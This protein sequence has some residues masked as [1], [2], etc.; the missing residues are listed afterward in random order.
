MMNRK[1]LVLTVILAVL[2]VL[3][4]TVF[5]ATTRPAM[6]QQQVGGSAVW[7]A[8]H[9]MFSTISVGAYHTLA[10]DTSGVLW[11]WGDNS[12]GAVGDGTTTYRS[13][14]VRIMENVVAVSAGSFLG[15]SY[16]L[17][18]QNDGSLWGWGHNFCG[19]LG[20]GT[21]VNPR[22]S[23]V[24]IMAN[25]TAFSTGAGHTLAIDT[26]GRL[27]AWGRN[28][29]GEL[30]D[31]TTTWRNSPVQ[32][33]SNIVQVSAGAGFS[34]AISA[35]NEL[36]AWGGN[37]VGQ[38]GDGTTTNRNRPTLIGENIVD[39]S[40]GTTHSLA[41]DTL[42]V[43]WA[44][45]SNS[46]GQL[47]D[48][49]TTN[50]L[51]PVVIMENVVG[52]SATRYIPT[53]GNVTGS[54]MALTVDGRLFT[55][56]NNTNG[57]LGDGTT[58]NR[59]RP[60]QIQQNII[61][62]SMGLTSAAA[63]QNDGTLLVWGANNRGQLGDG[64][65]TQRTSPVQISGIRIMLPLHRP[66]AG[67][68]T[69]SIPSANEVQQPTV[70][71]SSML[72]NNWG[73]FNNISH[74]VASTFR[75]TLA[76][77]NDG[78]LW[79]WGANTDGQLGDGTRT[80]RTRPV[81][82]MD[83]VVAVSS[84]SFGHSSGYSLALTSNGVLYGWGNNNS[85]QL[86][87]GSSRIR[88]SRIMDNIVAFS[89]SNAH[90]L[91][92]D[93][94]G[95]LWAW[96]SNSAGQL[97]DGTTT[98]RSRP[99][100]IG[101]N[102]VSVSAGA[103]HSMA[104]DASGNLFAWGS[105]S[106]GQLGDGTTTNRN[107]PVHIGSNVADVLAGARHTLAID[108]DGSLYGWGSN[109]AGQLG[110][111]STTD[112]HNPIFI[113]NNV[114]AIGA[115]NNARTGHDRMGNSLAV[116]SDGT[117]YSWGWNNFGNVGDGTTTNRHRPVPIMTHVAAVS[118]GSSAGAAVRTDGTLWTW[119][120]NEGNIGDGTTINRHSP[121][122]VLDIDNIMLPTN[123][124][125]VMPPAATTPLPAPTIGLEIDTLAITVEYRHDTV[126]ITY[127]DTVLMLTLS[128]FTAFG[129]QYYP[130]LEALAAFGAEISLNQQTQTIIIELGTT[131]IHI[132]LNHDTVV[133]NGTPHTMNFF[134][135]IIEDRVFVP[136]AVLELIGM[137][138]NTEVD[139][140]FA[141][142]LHIIYRGNRYD[143]TLPVM[144]INGEFMYPFREIAEIIG[145]TVTWDANMRTGSAAF[146]NFFSTFTVNQNVYIDN[147][148][149]RNLTRGVVPFIIGDRIYLPIRYVV[150]P[151]G[152]RFRLDSVNNAIIIE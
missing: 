144:N 92:I 43:L 136:L 29:F 31:G 33:A 9:N 19:N 23:P 11:A 143:L 84:G 90:T 107:R 54:S 40:A 87:N 66:F 8:N 125:F 117:L 7:V 27:W 141:E 39:V 69:V 134:P 76:L 48:G 71:S 45:G 85:G 70:H 127:R 116:T 57:Q 123:R 5:G 20:D 58:T 112:R 147:G 140:V 86:G 145:A 131:I 47:G 102:I 128:G 78:T 10:I 41:I 81:R 79:A 77:R 75:H 17:A 74:T 96:G 46:A 139:R 142:N 36:F 130:I 2:L 146:N 25:V 4:S 126:I 49:T 82:I 50:R 59:N 34:M 88:P 51:I 133:I 115:N 18:L 99:V 52:I 6:G 93:N 14:P 1:F 121:V 15:H 148:I 129:V 137:T 111:G 28:N 113:M 12:E 3:P 68:V 44:W 109:G 72:N 55:W 56:G 149:A 103:G 118:A 63:V 104:I 108:F 60:T 91:A 122:Q 98:N 65:T 24:R 94:Q 37:N 26:Q 42:G 105:N 13:T 106:N 100:Q 95:R 83:N 67:N 150:E 124:P 53:T 22:I 89:T 35:N 61:A 101:E 152:L 64:T 138:I 62:G 32:V 120:E 110:D 80:T 73:F 97:G 132:P 135:I 114:I 151:L 38:L 30:G 16:S 21:N 119:G